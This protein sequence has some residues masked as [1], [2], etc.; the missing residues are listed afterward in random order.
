MRA[1]DFEPGIVAGSFRFGLDQVLAP[2][3]AAT[4]FEE[5][6]E[7]KPLL[8]SRH[9]P[10]Y[11]DGLFSLRD[12]DYIIAS[13]DLRFPAVRMVKG[14]QAIPL[15][16][17]AEDVVWGNDVYRGTII[18]EKFYREYRAGASAVFQALH[19]A[20]QPLN[21]FCRDL[22]KYFH[23]HV[24]TN[25]YLT[26]KS[27]QGFKPHYDTHDVFILQIAGRKHWRVYEPPLTLPHRSQPPDNAKLRQ[28]PGQ[29]VLEI[30]LSPGDLLYLPRGFVH[31]ALTADTESLHITV[32]I[33][34]FT[35]IEVINEV[36]NGAIQRLKQEEIFR[37]S[38]PVG[39]TGEEEITAELKERLLDVVTESLRQ[40]DLGKAAYKLQQ[41]FINNRGALLEGHL[42]ELSRLDN[43]TLDQL[44]QQRP[45]NVYRLT[46]DNDQLKLNFHNKTVTFPGYTGESLRYIF[47]REETPFRIG[48]IG[49]CLDDDGKIVLVR[50]LVLEGFLKLA[51]E[52]NYG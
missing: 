10:G 21:L 12:L 36:M 32:G 16:R 44:V 27:A 6:W 15:A 46:D 49:G 11:Y 51:G 52:K 2:V 30:D 43:L 29:L 9:S 19:R 8:L 24:Q 23:H 39:F 13:T 41:R 40:A 1:S 5:Y 42:L 37:Q 31:E 14:G 50:R 35:Y 48:E 4:F 38:L 34:A 25:V 33:T 20:W 22:E 28:E 18:P 7:T 47:A 45:G 17:F 26:P 3:E